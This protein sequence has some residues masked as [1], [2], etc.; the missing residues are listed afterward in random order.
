MSL[1]VRKAP[2]NIFTINIIIIIRI[3]ISIIS[4][5]IIWHTEKALNFIRFFHCPLHLH[6]YR[7]ITSAV[8][9]KT[10]SDM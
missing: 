5:S 4:I 9:W 8:E 3:S 7:Q 10:S 6:H 1:S 2:L